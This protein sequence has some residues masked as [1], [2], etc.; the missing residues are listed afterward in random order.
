MAE[1]DAQVYQGA[2]DAGS[3]TNDFHALSFL[4]ERMVGRVA[5]ATIVKVVKAT[6]TP[7]QLAAVGKVDVLPLVNQLDGY[8]NA[9]PHETV[10]NLPYVRYGGGKNAVLVDP[11]VGDRGLV[12]FADRDIS[13]VKAK[14]DQA[15]P[16]SRRRHDMAD[17]VFL[18]VCLADAPEQYVR[19]TADGMELG[20]KHGNK[21]T[22]GPTGWTIN[23]LLINKDGDIITKKGVNLDTHVHS[24]V[25]SGPDNTAAPVV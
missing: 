5:V 15:N 23:G 2:A 17:G 24:G 20:D 12:V 19:F 14:R 7:G 16:G 1:G 21:M 11:E 13:S 4:A 25:T 18:G 8:G 22:S 6:N 9:T 3:A 10:Y